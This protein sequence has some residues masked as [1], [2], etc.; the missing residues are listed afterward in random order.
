MRRIRLGNYPTPTV[1]LERLSKQ[2]DRTIYIKRDDYS[3]IELSGNKTRK[4]EYALGEAMDEACTVIITAGAIQSN[5]ARATAAA[6]RKLGL[7]CHLVLFGTA[8]DQQMTG[9]LRYGG[10]HFLDGVLGATITYLDPSKYSTYLET[11]ASIKNDYA[12]KGQKAYI[13]PIGASNAVGTLGYVDCFEEILRGE[14]DAVLKAGSILAGE[15]RFDTI[16]CAVGSGGTFAGLW[17]GN[18]LNVERRKILGIAIG[19][20]AAHYK[21]VVLGILENMVVYT[22]HFQDIEET[23]DHDEMMAAAR[24]DLWIIDGYQG[25]GYAIPY[26]DCLARIKH[27]AHLEGVVLDPVYT[28]KAMHGLLT[29][30]ESGRLEN[31][32]CILFVHTGGVFGSFAFA[33]QPVLTKGK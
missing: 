8:P 5:H 15:K 26:D 23:Y 9:E 20:D 3:G 21:Q 1:K 31:S 24:K 27:V 17:L 2:M 13:V 22:D 7:D 28:G 14:F 10:N 19:A 12:E 6:C 16:V 29:E 25:Q 33:D 32:K 4:L 30:I 18:Y 11:L